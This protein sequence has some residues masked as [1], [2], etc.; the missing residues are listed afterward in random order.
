M[1]GR[2]VR[3]VKYQHDLYDEDNDY[4]ENIFLQK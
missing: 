4:T 3:L 1:R 2:Y